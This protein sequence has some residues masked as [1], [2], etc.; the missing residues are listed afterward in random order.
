M[1][2]SYAPASRP[3]W[4]STNRRTLSTV[5]P[6]TK[7][8]AGPVVDRPAR[9]VD[10]RVRPG[11]RPGTAAWASRPPA[12]ADASPPSLR[13]YPVRKTC[14]R[15]VR[16]ARPLPARTRAIPRASR[17]ARA[18]PSRRQRERSNRDRKTED[19]QGRPTPPGPEHEPVTRQVRERRAGGDREEGCADWR[20]TG[21]RCQDRD[22][23]HVSHNRDGPVQRVEAREPAEPGPHRRGRPV[24]P[25]PPLVPGEVVQHGTLDGDARCRR[26]AEAPSGNSM[27][28][29]VSWTVIPISPTAL[30]MNQRR[31]CAFA[32]HAMEGAKRPARGSRGA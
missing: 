15:D 27:D 28:N 5:R 10:A 32:S 1:T 22:E 6:G 26:A 30:K 11:A 8:R 19:G 18:P 13:R 9:H 20:Q 12:P 29:T 17:A 16:S 24:R 14:P 25:G 23:R 21:P 2:S 4:S 7:H 31:P 3:A